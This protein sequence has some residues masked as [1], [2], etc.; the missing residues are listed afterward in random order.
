MI[1]SHKY[2]F[3]FIKTKKTAGT[4][5]EIALSRFCGDDD[6]ITPLP[7]EDEKIREITGG[8][9]PQNYLIPKNKYSFYQSMK[10]KI[11]GKELKYFNHIYASDIKRYLP[12]NIWK[13]YYKFCFERNPWDKAISL[14]F[15][16]T[17]NLKERP[18][19]SEFL[20][21]PRAHKLSNFRIYS[22]NGKV[23]VDKIYKYEEMENALK[24]IKEVLFLPDNLE[25]PHTKNKSRKDKRDY[26]EFINENDKEYIKN[27][28]R[29]EIKILNYKY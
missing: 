19:F 23:A 6:V 25:L 28:C 5:L 8:K 9:G 22:N 15:W 2:K 18:S 14:Y 7:P 11:F 27:K 16:R 1:I 24:D 4:S 17:K 13:N 29:K 21:S 3:I 12:D 20:R 26:K 10:R